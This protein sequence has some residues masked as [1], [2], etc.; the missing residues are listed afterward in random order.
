ME[1]K[2]RTVLIE[3]ERKSLMTLETLLERYCP[4]VLVVGTARNVEEGFEVLRRTE[5]DLVFMDIAMPDGDAFDL[6]NRLGSIHFEIIFITAYNDYALKAFEFSALHYLLKPVNY[7]DLQAAV[8]R[9]IRIRPENQIQ[10]RIDILKQSMTNHI[11]RISLPSSDGLAIVSIQEIIRIEA[12]SNYS[13]V[14]LVGG[15]NIIVS[16]A[17]S[18]FEEILTGLNFIRIHNTHLINLRFVK[19]Y[20]RGQGGMV[21]LTDGTQLAVSKTRKNQFLEALKDHSLTLGKPTT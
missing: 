21:T 5:P 6:L 16:K 2:I 12:A 11:E 4:E 17:V 19:R 8:Q 14:Y 1:D 10:S 15:E 7:T 20:Q 3:D 13:F 9:F 18:Q